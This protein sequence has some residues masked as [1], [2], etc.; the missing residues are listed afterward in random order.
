MANHQV[1][2]GNNLSYELLYPSRL[3][4]KRLK[5]FLFILIASFAQ[6]TNAEIK[7]NAPNSLNLTHIEKQWLSTH[8]KITV[9]FDGNFPPYSF[10][11]DK[12][13][14]DGVAV[15]YFNLIEKKLGVHFT[16]SKI[17]L[18]KDMYKE[19][20]NKDSSIDVVATMVKKKEREKW[21]LFTKPYIFKSLVI[22][23]QSD[24]GII[25]RRSDLPYKTIAVVKQYQ[26][27]DRILKEFPS[28]VPYYVNTIQ[29]GLSAVTLGKADGIIAFV[30]VADWYRKKYFWK[31]LH[32]A[33]VYD[34]NSANE[35][36][37]V[38]KDWP[39][40]EQ[41]LQKAMNSIS[42]EEKNIITKRWLPNISENK[43]YNKLLREFLIVSLS[44]IIL[45][46]LVF[47]LRRQNK[48]IKQTENIANE[49][50]RKLL[51]LSNNLEEQVKLRTE[52]LFDLS[53][54]DPLTKVAN[55]N[56]FFK[57]HFNI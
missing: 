7:T 6:P 12:Q 18:W 52:K 43:D 3:M 51:S 13:Q 36:I 32:I 54:F 38:R 53:Y 45:L 26:Y 41:I 55:K 21:L 15:N 35:S 20:T 2:K 9:A 28:I 44:S 5:L 33:T 14:L 46:F 4:H 17:T 50:N 31:N 11:N 30:A 48:K 40:F 23:T 16:L 39:I 56:L 1:I 29:D 25:T 49:S 10:I 34:R 47:Y 19:V 37:A 8:P 42:V 57:S 27:V 22:V 24:N